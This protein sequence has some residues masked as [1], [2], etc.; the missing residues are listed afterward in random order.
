MVIERSIAGFSGWDREE[1]RR[2]LSRGTI[3]A[4]AA[5]GA[6]H[7]AGALYLYSL[8]MAPPALAPPQEPAPLLVDTIRLPQDQPRPVPPPPRR[9]PVHAPTQTAPKTIDPLPVRPDLVPPTLLKSD[10]PPPLDG[11]SSAGGSGTVEAPHPPPRTIHNPFWLAR[12]SAEQ[13]AEFYPPAALE[14]EIDGQAVLDCLVTAKGQLTD[15]KVSG[16]TPRSEGFGAAA[17]KASR[18]FR[19]SPKTE[20]GQPIEGGTVH[21]PIRFATQ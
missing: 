20:D 12:P 18:I 11:G 16:E 6:A 8:H 15:C 7:L 21:I 9:V 3:I 19:M 14:R 5:V 17:L 4:L 2:P 10:L 13:L 1:G